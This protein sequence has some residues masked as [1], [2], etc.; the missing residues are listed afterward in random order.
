M[1]CCRSFDHFTNRACHRCQR[2][3]TSPAV[4]SPSCG[5]ETPDSFRGWSIFHSLAQRS[6]SAIWGDL[7]PNTRRPASF[8]C[9]GSNDA[10]KGGRPFLGVSTEST[11]FI[12]TLQRPAAFL[13]PFPPFQDRQS[14]PPLH[15]HNTC[16][17]RDS[18]LCERRAGL[19][20]VLTAEKLGHKSCFDQT[21][22]SE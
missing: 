20:L 3:V 8:C 22:P 7:Y 19:S 9:F 17:C 4:P 15:C 16:L 14:L 12:K 5:F 10:E 6:C 18:W 1:R 21:R 2:A 13:D 11:M